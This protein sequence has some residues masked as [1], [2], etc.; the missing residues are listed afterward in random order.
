MPSGF[1][2]AQLESR[3]RSAVARRRREWLRII[4]GLVCMGCGY[5]LLAVSPDTPSEWLLPRVV[6]GFVALL[7]GA[8]AALSPL[9]E[10]LLQQ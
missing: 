4:A 10:R 7:G 3:E 9:L 6:L 5:G 2:N 8:A 1:R